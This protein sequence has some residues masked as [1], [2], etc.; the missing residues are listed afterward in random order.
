MS[1][2]SPYE[3]DLD[4]CGIT[5]PDEIAAVVDLL[6]RATAKIHCASDEDSDQDLVDFQVEE[7]IASGCLDR[8]RKEFTG[9]ITTSRSTTPTGSVRTTR[10][11]S[12]RS[13]RGASASPPP[14]HPR[15]I[16]GA[17]RGAERSKRWPT[18]TA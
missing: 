2:L 7:A 11:S 5:E 10:S 1:E 18:L 12:P 9:W 4:W 15:F 3:V 6:G 16:H 14:E 8:R 13:A 17:R